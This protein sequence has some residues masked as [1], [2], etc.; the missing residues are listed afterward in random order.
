MDLL[1]NP[2]LDIEGDAVV[3]KDRLYCIQEKEPG[4]KV[5]VVYRMPWKK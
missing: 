5:H 3:K 1:I 4:Y 2:A